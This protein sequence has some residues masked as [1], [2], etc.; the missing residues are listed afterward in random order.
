ML[1]RPRSSVLP[2]PLAFFLT[3]LLYNVAGACSQASKVVPRRPHGGADCKMDSLFGM[4]SS[5]M[6]FKPVKQHKEGSKR[7]QLHNYTRR[8]LGM[9]YIRQAVELPEDADRNEWMA[10]HAVDF[11]NAVSLLVGIA[12]DEAQ[13]RL[14]PGWGFPPGFEYLWVDAAT[15]KP[16]KCSGPEYIDHVLSWVEDI[17]NDENVFPTSTDARY[18]RDFD[19]TCKAIFKRLFRVFAILYTHSYRRIEG[20]GAVAHLNTTFKHFMFFCFEFDMV[21]AAELE[22]IDTLVD[23]MRTEYNTQG[24]N[25]TAPPGNEVVAATRIR[26]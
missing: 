24:A 5:K 7:Q 25:R 26:T 20:M 9:G 8:T 12:T 11:W 19:K 21:P 17:I 16:I 22:A 10:V 14:E 23:R 13:T 4:A 6:T 3:C 1:H 2:Q 18:P 15:R